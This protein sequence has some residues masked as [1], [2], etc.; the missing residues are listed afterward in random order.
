[1]NLV[2]IGRLGEY[3]TEERATHRGNKTTCYVSVS[4]I[5]KPDGRLQI[6]ALGV[7]NA[8][9]GEYNLVVLASE[10]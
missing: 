1:M 10:A 9:T 6:E 3:T 5:P 8:I 7:W 4:V 2:R